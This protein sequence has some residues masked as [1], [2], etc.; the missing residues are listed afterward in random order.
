MKLRFLTL[1]PNEE[2]PLYITY[3]L[4]TATKIARLAVPRAK[5]RERERDAYMQYHSL[6]ETRTG[7]KRMLNS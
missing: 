5:K 6:G 1:G 3:S 2:I 7:H 4:R